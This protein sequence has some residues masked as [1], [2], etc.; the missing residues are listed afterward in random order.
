MFQEP[1]SDTTLLYLI[2]DGDHAA[3]DLLFDRYWE[4]LYNAA[5]AR[6]GDD[7]VA[8]DIVQELFITIWQRRD[9]LTV[10]LSLESYLFSAVRL[11]VISHFR[12]RKVNE[13][14]LED[15]MHRVEYLESAVDTTADY[16]ELEKTLAEAVDRMPEM[17]QKVYTLRSENKTVKAIAGELGIAEQT[18]KNYT[19]EVSRRLRKTV[20]ERHPEKQATYLAI[21]IALLHN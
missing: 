5:H 17:L 9:V 19:A 15:A 14:R 6:V 10:Q 12:S 18:V 2:K 7:A 3:F 13:V 1:Q 16:L 11:S 21:I 4:R 20:I 8:Q